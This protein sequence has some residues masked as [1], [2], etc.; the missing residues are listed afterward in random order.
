MKTRSQENIGT[1][2]DAQLVQCYADGNN[3]CFTKLVTRHHTHVHN[4][5]H[6]KLHNAV[7]EKDAEQETFIAFA[8]EIRN[9]TYHD[10]GHLKQ[11]L[12]TIAWTQALI[13]IRKENPYTHNDTALRDDVQ[14]TETEE[15]IF[16]EHDTDTVLVRFAMKQLTPNHRLALEL[17]DVEELSFHD[18]GL[19]MN[20]TENN[21]CVTYFKA[22]KH[23]KRIIENI[24]NERRAVMQKRK[25]I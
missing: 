4:L 18:I 12:N 14:H 15:E 22:K 11:H 5:L 25:S 8:L 3:S 16:K 23:L 9:G 17:R 19:Q 6:Y 13:I 2:S 20:I 24:I 21:A 10:T 1:L 7:W